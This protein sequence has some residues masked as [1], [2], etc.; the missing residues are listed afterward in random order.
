MAMPEA[1][2][3]ARMVGTLASKAERDERVM[4]TNDSSIV[5]KCAVESLYYPKPH[6]YHYFVDRRKRR[7]PLV[8]RVYWLRM[9]C[10]D[11]TVRNFLDEPS[12]RAKVII[13]L[14]AGL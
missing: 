5:S 14:G 13:S 2:L 12:P 3:Q 4:A 9:R 11:S 10:V 7:A 8:S 6:F 1:A